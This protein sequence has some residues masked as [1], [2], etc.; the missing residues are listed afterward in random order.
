MAHILA[1]L[2][3]GTSLDGVDG[4]LVDIETGRPRHL[5]HVHRPFAEPLRAELLALNHAGTD[6]LARA[7]IAANALA[8]LCAEVVAALRAQCPDAH[9]RAIGCH[10][11]TVRH[12]PADGYTIQ[13]LNGALLAE[14]TGLDVV[15]DFRSRDVAAGGEGA[16]LVP[17]FHQAAF[18]DTAIHRVVVNI[19]GIANL[20]DLPPAGGA[21]GFDCG[22]GNLLLDAWTQRHRGEP[23]DRDGAWAAQGHVLPALLARLSA[24]AFFAR[25]PPKSSGRD[26]FNTDWLARG[27]TGNEM[28]ADVQATLLALSADTIADA[29]TRFCGDA[30]EVFLC[31]GGARNRTLAAALARRLAPRRLAATDALGINA[32]QVE[33]T[34]F[35]WLAG[36]TL[37]AQPG[38]LPSATGAR[39][40]RVLGA[41][42]RA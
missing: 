13:L 9:V 41:I 40:P 23:F 35:A 4:V 7:A 17:A 36:R 5:A 26:L 15:C 19:G 8:R 34:A 20:T 2:M 33:A 18:G 31:G 10:G 42:H 14:L 38:N 27:L 39:G 32:E 37:A 21:T 1:G 6:E 11:Q 28:P 12:Q 29:I 25:T 30:T 3:S 24:E 16:P 22:P